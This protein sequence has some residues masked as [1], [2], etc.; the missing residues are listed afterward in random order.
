VTSIVRKDSDLSSSLLKRS[1]APKLRN[2]FPVEVVLEALKLI[3]SKHQA[4]KLEACIAKYNQRRTKAVKRL[5]SEKTN[6]LHKLRVEGNIGGSLTGSLT[7]YIRMFLLF[8]FSFPSF[9]KLKFQIPLNL[10]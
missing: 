3:D 8:F 9:L 5:I 4:K 6:E 2:G 1:T 7:Q 10:C